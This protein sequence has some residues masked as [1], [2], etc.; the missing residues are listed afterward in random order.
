MINVPETGTPN[1]R[2]ATNC[3]PETAVVAAISV[4]QAVSGDWQNDKV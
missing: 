3:Q 2:A 1:F 4:I